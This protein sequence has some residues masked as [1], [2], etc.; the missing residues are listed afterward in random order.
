MMTLE[1]LVKG[2][3]FL[4]HAD[5]IVTHDPLWNH[6][7][8]EGIAHAVAAG[9]V[10]PTLRLWRY[11]QAFMLGRRD[12]R[13]PGFK[14][15]TEW[16]CAQGFDVAVRPSGGACV[17]LDQGVLN[18]SL[19][20]PI[21]DQGSLSIRAGF[22]ALADLI[23]MSLEGWSP[24]E[25]GEVFGSYCPGDFDIAISGYK[26]SGIAQRRIAGA[27]AIQAFLLVEGRGQEHVT[28][29]A[30]WYERAGLHLVEPKHRPLPEVKQGTIRS[31]NEHFLPPLRMDEVIHRLKSAVQR[32]RITVFDT[33]L[34]DEE[35]SYAIRERQRFSQVLRLPSFQRITS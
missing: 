26:F 24:V 16:A 18:V 8:D 20:L 12:E 19:I 22:E 15:A 14:Q 7:L 17:I 5:R 29:I 32:K 34:T 6:A 11:H 25:I 28:R 3:R 1:Q 33:G 30:E 4:N 21:G 2:I 35:H 13:L 23:S 31:M 10:Q 27:I 9:Q